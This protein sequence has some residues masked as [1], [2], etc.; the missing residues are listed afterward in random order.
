MK[1]GL[2]QYNPKWEDKL[3]NQEKIIELIRNLETN[4]DFLIFPEM[5]L[6]GFT[7]NVEQGE[8]F[9][10]QL[11]ETLKFFSNLSK[12]YSVNSIAGFIEKDGDKFFNTLFVIDR[13]GNIRAKYRKIHLFSFAAENKHYQAG[14]KLVSVEIENIKI[15]LSICYDLRFPELFRFYAKERVDLIVNI[16]NWPDSR[17]E[18]FVHLLKA[19]A[20][21]NQ[22]FVA[23]VNRVGYGK[24]DYYDGRSSIFDPLGNEIVSVKD[25]EKI[26][27][28]EIDL[29]L[30]EEVR[31]KF[32][33]LNDIRLILLKTN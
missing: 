2:V 29:R 25:E 15:G 4:P 13:E 6:T 19:R 28:A 22:C 20:I 18:H 26:I 7:M 21:E 24:K 1:L 5:S 17:I 31:R 33:F 32:P 14:E 3:A 12:I 16:A 27:I 10:L 9:D 23:G 11:S 30:I 8:I